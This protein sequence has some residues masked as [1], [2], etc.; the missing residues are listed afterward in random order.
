MRRM[1]SFPHSCPECFFYFPRVKRNKWIMSRN[2]KGT[3][4]GPCQVLILRV[5]RCKAHL[6]ARINHTIRHCLCLHWHVTPVP[7]TSLI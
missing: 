4:Q 2:I 5:R 3:M 1:K 7:F 6:N